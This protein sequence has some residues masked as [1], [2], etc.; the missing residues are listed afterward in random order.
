MPAI[1]ADDTVDPPIE[2]QAEIIGVESL[3]RT[4]DQEFNDASILISQAQKAIAENNDRDM[5]ADLV[6]AIF[7]T[8]DTAAD[9]PVPS[10]YDDMLA[11]EVK[12]ARAQAFFD[13]LYQDMRMLETAR[14][15][16][17]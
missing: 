6:Y 15:A 2:A 12:R 4:A 5:V 3:M 16:A 8:T 10:R 13:A 7:Y 14:E 1:E 17:W 11:K 9:P